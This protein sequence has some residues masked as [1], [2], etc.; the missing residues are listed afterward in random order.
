VCGRIGCVEAKTSGWALARDLRA[1]GHDI[2][3]SRG[4]VELIRVRDPDAMRLVNEGAKLLGTAIADA[5]NVLNPS[6]V[7]R[8]RHRQRARAPALTVR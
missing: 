6:T 2:D 1:L 5:V 3:G 7:V 8:R 4:V